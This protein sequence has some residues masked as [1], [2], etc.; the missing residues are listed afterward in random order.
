MF[1]NALAIEST[2]IGQFMYGDK[3]HVVKSDR[4]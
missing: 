4:G 2:R 1:E 3:R